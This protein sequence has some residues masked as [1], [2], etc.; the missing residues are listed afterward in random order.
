[1]K[2]WIFKI[3]M[4]IVITSLVVVVNQPAEPKPNSSD[5]PTGASPNTETEKPETNRLRGAPGKS[6]L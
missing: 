2:N 6:R 1:M 4:V 5:A 3:V